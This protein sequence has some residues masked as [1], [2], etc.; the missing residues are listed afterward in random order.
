M[1]TCSSSGYS[2]V[3]IDQTSRHPRRPLIH[4]NSSD[5]RLTK[6]HNTDQLAS[7]IRQMR[8]HR[9]VISHEDVSIFA[10]TA[11]H[12]QR[13]DSLSDRSSSRLSNSSS[14]ISKESEDEY[15]PPK[16]NNENSAGVEYY[17]RINNDATNDDLPEG[18]QEVKEGGETYYW[19][20]WTGTI[21]YER[22]TAMMV[23]P[24]CEFAP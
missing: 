13:T 21:Q 12:Q 11:Q 14:S 23:C 20:I 10:T 3:S 5:D 2:E 17:S 8:T 22:P 24:R 7:G 18:W 9:R 4:T 16:I 1:A 19:H 15:C 6:S